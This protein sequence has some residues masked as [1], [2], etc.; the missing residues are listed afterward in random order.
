VLQHH[1]SVSSIDRNS[2][3]PT[4]R[5]HAEIAFSHG[6]AANQINDI[7]NDPKHI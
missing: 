6:T 7:S 4:K 1:R 5:R 3:A 2:I